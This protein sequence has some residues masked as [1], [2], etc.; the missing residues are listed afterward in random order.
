MTTPPVGTPEDEKDSSLLYFIMIIII[1]VVTTFFFGP[2]IMNMFNSPNIGQQ[3]SEQTV[4]NL[5]SNV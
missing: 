2:M 5:L 4:T 3:F 1:S